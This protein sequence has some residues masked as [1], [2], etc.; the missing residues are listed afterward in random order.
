M[1]G[2][3]MGRLPEKGTK[4]KSGTRGTLAFP[5]HEKSDGEPSLNASPAEK[6]PDTDL[7]K[8]CCLSAFEI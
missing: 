4:R 7:Q 3:K 5:T 6:C 2:Q 8:N 1:K